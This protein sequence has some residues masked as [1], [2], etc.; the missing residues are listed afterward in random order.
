MAQRKNDVRAFNYLD[1]DERLQNTCDELGLYDPMIL[2]VALANGKDLTGE[3]LLYKRILE[4]EEANGEEPPDQ[5][6]WIAMAEQIKELNRYIPVDDKVKMQAQKTIAE[7]MHSK[8]KSVEITNNTA[9]VKVTNLKPSEIR[10]FA[11]HFN[12][13]Y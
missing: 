13:E 9:E 2:L 1:L 12:K 4:H 10:R 8:K 5:D 11:R 6:E 7:Y 3:S